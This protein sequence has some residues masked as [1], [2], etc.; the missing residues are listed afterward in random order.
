MADDVFSIGRK[1]DSIIKEKDFNEDNVTDLLKALQSLPMSLEMLQVQLFSSIHIISVNNI[2][3]NSNIVSFQKTRVGLSVNTIRKRTQ[4]PELASLTKSL[5]KSW[6]KLVPVP[7]S[8]PSK[9]SIKSEERI[10]PVR[11]VFC[12]F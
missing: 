7:N 9:D 1:L 12:Y 8:K 6:K 3:S 5:I 4:N 2:C 11:F 10:E